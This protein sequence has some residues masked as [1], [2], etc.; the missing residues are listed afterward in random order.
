MWAH[1]E[2]KYLYLG[3]V[4]FE[5]HPSPTPPVLHMFYDTAGEN[6]SYVRFRKAIRRF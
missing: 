2:R 1:R 3:Q 4:G 5:R 6:Y